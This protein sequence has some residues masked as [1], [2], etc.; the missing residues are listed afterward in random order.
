[1]ISIDPT[2]ARST[3]SYQTRL[4]DSVI[5]AAV[6]IPGLE[7]CTGADLIVSTKSLPPDLSMD[8]LPIPVKRMFE[9][10]TKYALFVQRK[11][12]GDFLSSIPDLVRIEAR[13]MEW[14]RPG[15]CWL[16]ITALDLSTGNADGRDS[17]WTPEAVQGALL[18]WQLRG[19]HVAI[20]PDDASI[21]AWLEN[22]DKA[23]LKCES[24]PIR[25]THRYHLVDWAP[26]Q[27]TLKRPEASEDWQTTGSAFPPLFGEAKRYAVWQ[28]LYEDKLEPTLMNAYRRVCG[29]QVHV[30]GIGPK[31]TE[32]LIEWIG[33]NKEIDK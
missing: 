29:G 9:R 22:M 24:E 8:P 2:E 23:M 10:A 27:A 6:Q 33:W 25:W 15:G 17:A 26:L 28:S 20:L 3:E 31:L 13:M 5:D 7:A 32:A 1:V 19:G 12:G 14:A 30:K 18:W 4:P 11:S 21:G 16:L